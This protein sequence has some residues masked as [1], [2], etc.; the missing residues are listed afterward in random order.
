[1]LVQSRCL[2]CGGVCEVLFLAKEFFH[3]RKSQ[4]GALQPVVIC[5]SRFLSAR[6]FHFSTWLTLP[7]MFCLPGTRSLDIEPKLLSHQGRSSFPSR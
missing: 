5:F 4:Y 2:I 7:L 1:M 6:I 3:I